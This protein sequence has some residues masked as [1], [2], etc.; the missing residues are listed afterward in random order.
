[1]LFGISTTFSS[2]SDNEKVLVARVF[3]QYEKDISNFD[4]KEQ[5]R[6]V[7]LLIDNISK[8]QNTSN[9]EENQLIYDILDELNM[10]ATKKIN[11]LNS[12]NKYAESPEMKAFICKTL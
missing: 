8:L 10:L 5:L 1:M 3:S 7:N 6:R 9:K 2:L 4:I 11:E 12:R